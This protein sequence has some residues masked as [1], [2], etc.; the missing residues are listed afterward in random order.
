M[1]LEQ[2][3]Q[4]TYEYVLWEVQQNKENN[5]E[6]LTIEALVYSYASDVGEYGDG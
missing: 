3:V 5:V 6:S 1:N 4:K 2:I